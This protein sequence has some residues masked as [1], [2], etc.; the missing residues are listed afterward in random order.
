M[1][2]TGIILEHFNSNYVFLSDT[3]FFS[4]EIKG[5]I[6]GNI[7][8]QLNESNWH[9]LKGTEI[10]SITK[11]LESLLITNLQ[12]AVRTF[13][14]SLSSNFAIRYDGIDYLINLRSDE[15]EELSFR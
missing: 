10:S 4:R 3:S 1:N 15:G 11:N 9:T 2:N 6:G 12:E 7:I 8:N 5:V 14:P 13:E